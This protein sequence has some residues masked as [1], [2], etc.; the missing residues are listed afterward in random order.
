MKYDFG[1][2]I[3]GNVLV[4]GDRIYGPWTTWF[5]WHPTKLN[6]KRVWLRNVYRRQSWLFAFIR[7]PV[8]NEYGTLLDILKNEH[9]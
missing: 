4:P 7:S 5:A 8:R 2:G 1:N 9:N 6:G 3:E